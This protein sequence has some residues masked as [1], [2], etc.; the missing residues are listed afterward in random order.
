MHN[1]TQTSDVDVPVLIVGGGGAGLTSSILL[2]RLGVRSL[3]VT[4]YPETTRLPRGHILNQRSMEIF[5]DMGVAPE[6]KAKGTPPENMKGVAWYSGLGGGGPEDGHGRLLGFVEAWGGGYTDPDYIAASPEPCVNLSLLR[7]EPI[8]K[9]H[10]ESYPEATVR[11]HHELVGLEQD[12]DGVTSTILDRDSGETYTVRSSYLLGA[13]AGRTVAELAGVKVT[14]HER[15]RKLVSLYLAMDLSQHLP[16]DD[17][18]LTWVFNPEYPEHLDYG[19][20]L[21]PQGP[22]RWDRHSEEWLLAVSRPDLD[23]SQPEKMLRWASEALG[24]PDLDPEVLGVSEWYLERF[25]V[26]DFRAGRVFLLGDA[27][28]RVPPSGGL[29][30]N[31]AVQDAYNLCWK[32]A[33]VLAGRAGDGLL[34]TYS[35]ERRPV[36]LNNIE[37]STK[38]VSGQVSMASALG[39]STGKSAEENWAE[40]SLFW[41]DGAPGAAERRHAFNE[42]LAA[43]TLEYHQHNLDYGYVYESAAVVADGTGKPVSPDEIRLYQPSTRPGHPLPHAWVERSGERLALRSLTHGGH[44][45]LIA[46]EDGRPWIEAAEKIAQARQLPLRSARVGLDK[47]DLIDIR[48]AWQ[49]NRAISAQGALLVRPDGHVAYR[50][51]GAADDPVAALTAVLDQI[52][53]VEKEI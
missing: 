22:E 50:S 18:V 7:T 23:G 12:A 19:A 31:S 3:L 9:S 17:S 44:F 48:L 52:L 26:D 34:D 45:A 27:A 11:F 1:V 40:L 16:G 20:V 5:T 24:I 10:A 8:L 21:V 36:N 15:F 32:L 14:M 35:A 38:S 37:A 2:S 6:I 39:L 30:L 46:G 29:G 4:R 41:E 28:H 33:A 43:S 13:D 25:L 53:A 51:I 42:W 49:R 47:V